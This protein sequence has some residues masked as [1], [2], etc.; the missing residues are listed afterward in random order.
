MQLRS[1]RRQE[2][3]PQIQKTATE[4]PP[5]LPPTQREKERRAL[6]AFVGCVCAAFVV[7]QG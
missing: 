2:G 6:R 4:P 5:H 7:Q 3:D 1:S